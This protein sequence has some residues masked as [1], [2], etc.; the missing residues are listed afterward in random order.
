MWTLSFPFEP[1][2]EVHGLEEPAEFEFR[3]LHAKIWGAPKSLTIEIR[4]FA[5]EKEAGDFIPHVWGGLAA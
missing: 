1:T 4:G 3:S 2:D 5:T